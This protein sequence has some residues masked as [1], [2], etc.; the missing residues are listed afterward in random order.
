VP[1]PLLILKIGILLALVA[2]SAFFIFHWA[3]NKA[4]VDWLPPPMIL[5]EFLIISYFQIIFIFFDC[6]I[7]FINYLLFSFFF[8][9]FQNFLFRIIK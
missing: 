6:E 2:L 1:L 4:Q 3:D 8:H 7:H 9:F 5:S